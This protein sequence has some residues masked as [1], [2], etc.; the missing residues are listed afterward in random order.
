MNGKLK[1]SQKKTRSIYGALSN[2]DV[3]VFFIKIIIMVFNT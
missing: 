3:G 1:I 2:I